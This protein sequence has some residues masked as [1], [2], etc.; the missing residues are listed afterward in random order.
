MENFQETRLGLLLLLV[1]VEGFD[2]VLLGLGVGTFVC[3]GCFIL[4][5]SDETN[6]PTHYDE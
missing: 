5:Q 1:V 3:F 4:Y 6:S 2:F